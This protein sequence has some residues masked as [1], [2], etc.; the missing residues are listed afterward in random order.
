MKY[1]VSIYRGGLVVD[2][3]VCDY[4]SSKKLGLKCPFCSEAVFLRQGSS[5]KRGDKPIEVSA[6]FCHYAIGDNAGTECELRSLRK[7]GQEYLQELEIQSRN[8]R[9]EIYNKYLWDIFFEDMKIENKHLKDVD[10]FALSEIKD[11]IVIEI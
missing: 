2:A 4:E 3:T 5:Y 6:A 10:S 1:A 9:L 11:E 8:Q 7:D